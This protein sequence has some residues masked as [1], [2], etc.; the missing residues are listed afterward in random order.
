MLIIHVIRC[1]EDEYNLA[2]KERQFI[3]IISGQNKLESR[4][5]GWESKLFHNIRKYQKQQ[6]SQS[7]DRMRRIQRPSD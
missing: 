3:R 1:K 6:W 4:G 2:D 5:A 7:R